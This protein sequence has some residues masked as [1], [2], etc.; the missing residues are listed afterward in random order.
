MKSKD[1]GF[2]YV[3][4]RH[5]VY[6]IQLY[7][8]HT[9]KTSC[10]LTKYSNHYTDNDHDDDAKT[11]YHFFNQIGFFTCISGDYNNHS[12]HEIHCQEGENI[13]KMIN[14]FIQFF[15]IGVDKDTCN[16]SSLN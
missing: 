9:K 7:Y 12:S 16:Y 11:P 13:L 14:S 3:T 8:N 1:S 2:I 6:S 4:T 10:D 5:T 15:R